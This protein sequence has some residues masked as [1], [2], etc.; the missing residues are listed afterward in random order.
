MKTLSSLFFM[1]KIRTKK[2]AGNFPALE[3]PGSFDQPQQ[4]PGGNYLHREYYMETIRNVM[5]VREIPNKTL[6]W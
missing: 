6:Q 3:G 5:N 4:P 2:L 1:R